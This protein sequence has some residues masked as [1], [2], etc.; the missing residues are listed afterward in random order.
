MPRG[1]GNNPQTTLITR[2]L[3]RK[4][5]HAVVSEERRTELFFAAALAILKSSPPPITSQNSAACEETKEV[6]KVTCKNPQIK[7][8]EKIIKKLKGKDAN[9]PAAVVLEVLIKKMRE[10]NIPPLC[11]LKTL[12]SLLSKEQLNTLK[13]SSGEER[14]TIKDLEQLFRKTSKANTILLYRAKENSLHLKILRLLL[15][16][17]DVNMC[18]E[19]G[20]TVWM[21]IVGHGKSDVA[22]ALK[23]AGADV[24]AKRGDRTLLAHAL[25]AKPSCSK[26]VKNLIDAGADLTVRDGGLTPLM[27]AAYARDFE[28]TKILIYAGANLNEK[29]KEGD[30]ILMIAE[31]W[32]PLCCLKSLALIKKTVVILQS[33]YQINNENINNLPEAIRLINRVR[34]A[35]YTTNDLDEIFTLTLCAFLQSNS[36][37]QESP[38]AAPIKSLV[39]DLRRELSGGSGTVLSVSQQL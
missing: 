7:H 5:G 39:D 32:G 10:K 15:D 1:I 33:A 9:H 13:N 25:I 4:G 37:I 20:E 14:E 35:V 16:F 27:H 31:G 26:T 17:C 38:Y 29:T 11:D 2:G 22:R 24:N 18:D 19:F 12:S 3:P 21:L 6:A 8:I 30:S 34:K 36:P 23:D 28:L